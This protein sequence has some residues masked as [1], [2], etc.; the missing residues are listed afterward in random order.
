M[1]HNHKFGYL[2]SITIIHSVGFGYAYF[3]PKT[4]TPYP[5]AA[6]DTPSSFFSLFLTWKYCYMEI[7]CTRDL[8]YQI[9]LTRIDCWW[10][11]CKRALIRFQPCTRDF[12]LC[13]NGEI[14]QNSPSCP[15]VHKAWNGKWKEW[16]FC[17]CP[18]IDNGN[19]E[20]GKLCRWDILYGWWEYAT[21]EFF[22]REFSKS[23]YVYVSWTW[24][25]LRV[26]IS[27]FQDIPRDVGVEFWILHLTTLLHYLSDQ[28][29]SHYMRN[30][31]LLSILYV[32]LAFTL[33]CKSIEIKTPLLHST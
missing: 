11:P 28:L 23:R 18:L 14:F 29:I 9:P 7:F 8:W 27:H 17:T 25:R 3:M 32:N 16:E 15:V 19:I 31:G 20:H 5:K 21:W 33:S 22:K 30:E 12:H 10:P 26:D 24:S 4:F 1:S 13:P 2:K 6:K